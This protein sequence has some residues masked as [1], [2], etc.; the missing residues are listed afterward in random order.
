MYYVYLATSAILTDHLGNPSWKSW[1]KVLCN[2]F[3]SV[4]SHKAPSNALNRA[5][6]T[7]PAP[8]ATLVTT[9]VMLEGEDKSENEVFPNGYLMRTHRGTVG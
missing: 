2:H 7:A 8:S 6:L 4:A 5:I 9:S 3:H 1:A